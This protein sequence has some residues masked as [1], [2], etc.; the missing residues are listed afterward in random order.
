LVELKQKE[1]LDSIAY[2]KRIQAALLANMEFINQNVRDHFVLFNPKDIVSGDFYWVAK[3]DDIF[4]LAVCDSTGHGVPGAFMSLLN[5]GFLSQAVLEKQIEKPNEI[6]NYVRK[7]LVN[8]ISKEGQQDG[9]DGILL[10]I[11]KRTKEILYAS[12]NNAP[13]L[14]TKNGIIHPPYDKMPVGK[15]V[16]EKPFNLYS[17]TLKSEDTLY[18]YTDGYPDQFG[19]PNGKKFKYKQLDQLLLANSILSLEEQKQQLQKHFIEWKGGLEQVDD[20]C[21]IGIRF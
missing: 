17:L 16:V 3:K 11:N 7:R 20:V 14:I 15:G 10:S 9:F 12:A 8:T 5:M 21:I 13:V 19:G 18:L 2:A 1:I 6:L 4:Y